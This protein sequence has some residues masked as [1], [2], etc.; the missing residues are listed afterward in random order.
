[1]GTIKR[2]YFTI[3]IIIIIRCALFSY[4]S[5]ESQLLFPHEE[6]NNNIFIPR[7]TLNMIIYISYYIYIYMQFKLKTSRIADI[8]L[9]LCARLPA[10]NFSIYCEIKVLAKHQL[11]RGGIAVYVLVSDSILQGN[12]SN[13]FYVWHINF[14]VLKIITRRRTP[15]IKKLSTR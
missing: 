7:Y 8:M 13:V 4:G 14:I 10:Q 6:Y 5:M 15:E 11:L 3:I 2:V 9:E 12:S 1:M